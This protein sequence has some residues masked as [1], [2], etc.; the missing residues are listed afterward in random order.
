MDTKSQDD[1]R[2]SPVSYWLASSQCV[3]IRCFHSRII[4]PTLS[5]AT[6]P[7]KLASNTEAALNKSFEVQGDD[8]TGYDTDPDS[9]PSVAVFTGGWIS[10]LQAGRKEYVVKKTAWDTK[11]FT[12]KWISRTGAKVKKL[13]YTRL[14]RCFVRE[15]RWCQKGSRDTF[16]VVPSSHRTGRNKRETFLENHFPSATS[17]GKCEDIVKDKKHDIRKTRLQTALS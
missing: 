6:A 17:V 5:E 9:E 8:V 4:S 13:T 1:F 10:D 16:S 11:K 3:K 2:A 12:I 7:T 14:T 15:Q